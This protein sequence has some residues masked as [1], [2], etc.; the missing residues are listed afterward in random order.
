[1]V[2]RSASFGPSRSRTSNGH[3]PHVAR[4]ARY[5]HLFSDPN[6]AFDW[7]TSAWSED[8]LWANPGDGQGVDSQ[9]NGGS[10]GTA[11]EQTVAASE[12]TFDASLPTFNG[13]A[14]VD[15]DGTD[16]KLEIL[17]GVSLAT[18]FSV[19]F[20]GV[21]D[22]IGA[23]QV[24]VGLHTNGT[25]RGLRVSA[26]GALAYSNAAGTVSSS[27]GIVTA[28]VPFFAAAYIDGSTVTITLNGTVVVGPSVLAGATVDQ[29]IIGSGR[30]TGTTYGNPL[31][32][33]T[34]FAGVMSG[35]IFLAANASAFVDFA[36]LRGVPV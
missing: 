35:N 3:H 12:P 14:A 27:A 22:T 11:L 20:L 10:L 31:D 18:P 26:T 4:Y 8:P 30:S 7:Y 24:L 23:L 2:L 9:R 29:F 33:K 28:G 1:M 34:N 36:R 13:Y 17:T 19:V 21:S 15:Y 5:P 25:G 16:D 6:Q 32:G